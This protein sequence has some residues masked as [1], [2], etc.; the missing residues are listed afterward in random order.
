VAT[1]E[2]TPPVAATTS[3]AAPGWDAAVAEFNAGNYF[4][5]HE[6]WEGLWTEA[7][8]SEKLL[9]QGLVQVAAGY[10]K[11][12]VGEVSGA[13]KLFERGLGRLDHGRGAAVGVDLER[14]RATVEDALRRLRAIPFG[15]RAGLEAVP[16]P[17][18]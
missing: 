15:V 13:R 18:L 6:I 8:G 1:T 11:L 4:E 12:A 9:Y 5:A 16:K 10:A 3:D 14:L 17:E 7:V 2:M